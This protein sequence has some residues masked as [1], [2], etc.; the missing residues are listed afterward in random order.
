MAEKHVDKRNVKRQGECGLAILFINI[1]IKPQY[2]VNLM[3]GKV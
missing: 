2:N 1:R 3:I